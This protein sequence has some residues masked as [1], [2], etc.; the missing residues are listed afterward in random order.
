MARGA[1]IRFIGKLAD[2]GS[3][4]IINMSNGNIV[5]AAIDACQQTIKLIS[6]VVSYSEEVT[7]TGEIR[8]QMTY[9]KET[10]KSGID[11][12]KKRVN[13]NLIILKQQLHEKYL[14]E[15]LNLKNEL[16]IYKR[17]METVN[18]NVTSSFEEELRINRMTK[19]LCQQLNN[20]LDD[21]EKKIIEI[22][23][24]EDDKTKVYMLQEDFRSVQQQVVKL[25]KK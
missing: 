8:K 25:L 19:K 10:T 20:I 21:I 15:E 4:I 3:N 17:E 11:E 5:G 22:D 13:E 6:S 23:N 12:T 2:E 16:E 7:R 9:K 18:L 1:A 14:S 24:N